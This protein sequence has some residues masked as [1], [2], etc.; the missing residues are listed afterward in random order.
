MSKG[1]RP[2]S[3][4]GSVGPIEPRKGAEGSSFGEAGEAD[5][6]KSKPDCWNLDLV[7]TTENVRRV[8]RKTAVKGLTRSNRIA[9]SAPGIGI[10]GYVPADRAQRII[11]LSRERGGSL[12]GQ[13][14]DYDSKALSISVVLCLT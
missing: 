2:K 4:T 13:V 12:T 11:E 6:G 10:L 14:T 5:T 7:E 1:R 8:Q 9:V 3:S